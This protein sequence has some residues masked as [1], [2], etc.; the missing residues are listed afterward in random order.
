MEGVQFLSV[1]KLETRLTTLKIMAESQP[2]F[3]VFIRPLPVPELLTLGPFP[4][5]QFKD[6]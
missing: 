4:S 2:G 1:G 6:A 3:L 5:P